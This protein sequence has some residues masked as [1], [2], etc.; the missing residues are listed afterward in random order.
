MA[1][2]VARSHSRFGQRCVRILRN[3]FSI[4]TQALAGLLFLFAGWGFHDLSAFFMNPAR[5][6]FVGLAVLCAVLAVALG[7][8]MQPIRKGLLPTGRQSLELSAL[9]A[10]SL[11]LL[12]FL[13]FADRRNLVTFDCD[14]ARYAGLAFCGVGA[15]IR[16]VALRS[17]GEQFSAYV[18]LQPQ[19]RLVQN[20]IYRR[21]RHPLYL[22]L[23]LVPAG[24]AMVFA[25]LLAVPIFAASVLFVFDRIRK[26]ERLLTN[27]FG[28]EFIEYRRRT[29]NLVPHLF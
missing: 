18:T 19:H 17:L 5:A 7:V 12:W 13:P 27:A 4:S 29:W 9:L 16:L 28:P 26:E 20:G 25:S 6:S 2:R 3:S 10:C 1:I 11:G 14:P 21:I 22:S 8:E 23:L 24:I 15:F